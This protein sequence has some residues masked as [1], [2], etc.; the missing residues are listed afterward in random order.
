MKIIWKI[1]ELQEVSVFDQWIATGRTC[2]VV[3]EAFSEEFQ[4]E[5]DALSFLS[6]NLCEFES[7][8]QLVIQKIVVTP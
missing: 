4:S 7:D 3:T 5:E 1:F 6:Q 8:E 2:C